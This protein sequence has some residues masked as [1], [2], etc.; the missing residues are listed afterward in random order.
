M[1]DGR[2]RAP[3]EWLHAELPRWVEEGVIDAAAAD[4]IR[5]R[6]AS[7]KDEAKRSLPWT[8]VIFGI[9][10]AV[11]VGG[12]IVLL[13]AHNWEWMTRP[14]RTVVAFAPLLLTQ[15]LVFW[16]LFTGRTSP[17][18]REPAG[19]L[20]AL[21][22]GGCLALVSQTYH[23]G[24]SLPDFML[25]WTLL[26][27][28]LA[29]LLR[30]TLPAIWHGGSTAIWGL[31]AL[32][33]RTHA[34]LWFWPLLALIVPMWWREVR[35]DRFHVRPVLI[36]W[37]LALAGI[38]GVG[39]ALEGAHWHERHA[40]L[41][42]AGWF[43]FLHLTGK[44]CFADAR[45]PASM[46]FQ[47]VGVVGAVVVAL[48]L[49]FDGAGPGFD[50]HVVLSESWTGLRS[51]PLGWLAAFGFS[52]LACGMWIPALIRRDATAIVV[53]ALPILIVILYG[54]FPTY[55]VLHRVMF[56]AYVFGAG[57]AV[58]VAGLRRQALGTVNAG[59]AVL[60]AWV[61]CRF[62]DS[63]MSFVVRGLVFIALGIG[64]LGTNLL[65]VRRRHVAP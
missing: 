56:N 6:F 52:V 14:A 35:A 22:I 41:A 11:L 8:L 5:A 4:R 18:W 61:L 59:M 38:F 64:F 28:P 13:L 30:A 54:A 65:L 57:V 53:G 46:P 2:S 47:T 45:G 10:G 19:T 39:V 32:D 44:R 20:T 37:A 31:S 15:A 25:G 49:T 23:L 33:Q 55:G 26:A 3:F 9:I 1:Q 63:D 29:Y 36:G 58:L 62:F 60:A 43:A 12:G 42:Y 51:Q 16:I 34:Y 17:A 40:A 27:L 21:A 7:R 50:G 24:G 48:I